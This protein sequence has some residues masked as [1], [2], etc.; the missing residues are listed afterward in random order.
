MAAGPT[1]DGAGAAKMKTLEAA[2]LDVQ[3]LH[4]LVE[5]M[6][7]AV[8]NSQPSSFYGGQVKR[9]ATPLIGQL[10]GQ[11]GMIADQ[12]T[13]MVLVATR[14]GSEQIKIRTLREHIG[15]IRQALEIAATKVKEKHMQAGEGSKDDDAPAAKT[16]ADAGA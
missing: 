1:L 3:H 10:K 5:R 4:S 7:T 11:F 2:Q 9:A 16:V 12:V 6:A 14:G 15:Q 13:A 8:K